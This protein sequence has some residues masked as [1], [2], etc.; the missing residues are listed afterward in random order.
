MKL[1]SLLKQLPALPAQGFARKAPSVNFQHST[2]TC[3]WLVTLLWVLALV[4]C[5][6]V[7]DNWMQLQDQETETLR[8]EEQFAAL[9]LKQEKLIQASIKTSPEQKK[10]LEAFAQQAITPYALLDTIGKAWNQELAIV[11]M[12]VRTV[13]REVDMTL[14][15]KTLP[16]VF[17]FIERLKSDA[18]IDVYLQQSS[19]NT[20]EPMQPFSIKLGLKGR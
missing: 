12:E 15:S 4:L 8:V 10:Q 18:T 19:I 16:D 5:T 17:R 11:R 9:A 7:W 20:K 2:L 3:K 13:T 14:E 6:V 1:Q